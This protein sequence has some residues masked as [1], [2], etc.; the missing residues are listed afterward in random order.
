LGIGICISLILSFVFL[1]RARKKILHWHKAITGILLCWGIVFL[2]SSVYSLPKLKI[3]NQTLVDKSEVKQTLVYERVDWQYSKWLPTTL[4]EYLFFIAS[5]R[6]SFQDKYPYAQ[7]NIDMDVHFHNAIDV[8]IYLPRSAQIAFLTPFPSQ[9]FSQG[10]FDW[11]TLMRRVTALEMIGIYLALLLLPYSLW[12]WRQRVEVWIL[13]MLCSGVIIVYA[14][15]VPNIGALHRFR[16]GFLMALVALGI[17]GGLRAYQRYR[18]KSF[19]NAQAIK[20]SL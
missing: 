2:L 20:S 15:A 5:T 19:P 1:S 16:Y 8:F 14:L 4:D 9:W 12:H 13:A 18:Q 10:S 7:S 17:A 3:R 11:T 6:K